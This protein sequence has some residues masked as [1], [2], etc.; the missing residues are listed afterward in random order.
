MTIKN[1]LP[2]FA[3][4]A[5]ALLRI[6]AGAMFLCHGL[7]KVFGALGG[8]QATVGSQ[9][10]IGGLIELVCGAAIAL[11]LLT[12]LAA[13]LASG[14]MAVAYLQFHW[15]LRFDSGFFPIVNLGELALLY[16][17]VFLYVAFRGD[18]VWAVGKV[19]RRTGSR[20]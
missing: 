12:S 3:D 19:L 17:F 10:W 18:G 14:E 6:V 15:K 2:G 16:S 13:F 1:V 8:Q 9:F 4:R 20:I 11:G 7:Q 5:Y